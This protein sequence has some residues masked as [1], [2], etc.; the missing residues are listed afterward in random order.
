MPSIVWHVMAARAPS[1]TCNVCPPAFPWRLENH[2][3]LLFSYFLLKNGLFVPESIKQTSMWRA[4]AQKRDPREA[5]NMHITKLG[6]GAFAPAIADWVSLD[7][8]AMAVGGEVLPLLLLLLLLLLVVVL[9]L[10][11]RPQLWWAALAALRTVGLPASAS[12]PA[13]A[14]HCPRAA[15]PPPSL[16]QPPRRARSQPQ[17][18]QRRLPTRLRA[19]P[20]ARPRAPL[21][22]PKPAKERM[23]GTGAARRLAAV[24]PAIHC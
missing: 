12:G 16:P 19:R 13:A 18:A 6:N 2:A 8:P 10:L 15:L 4:L 22:A 21:A 9:L 1:Q 17:H 24:H 20:L 5:R 11:L 14:A 7:S 3:L 23:R